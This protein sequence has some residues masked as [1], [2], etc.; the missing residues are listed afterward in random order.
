MSFNPWLDRL[1]GRWGDLA[2]SDASSIAH[3]PPYPT[4]D[5]PVTPDRHPSSWLDVTVRALGVLM[6]GALVA[7][8]CSFVRLLPPEGARTPQE[9]L[10]LLLVL[11]GIGLLGLLCAAVPAVYG[12]ANAWLAYGCAVTLGASSGLVVSLGRQL[13]VHETSV[14]PG[15]VSAAACV[16]LAVAALARWKT[17]AL[18]P[19]TWRVAVHAVVGGVLLL[20]FVYVAEGVGEFPPLWLLASSAAVASLGVSAWSVTRDVPRITAEV[21]DAGGAVWMA[22]FALLLSPAGGWAALASRL[23]RRPRPPLAAGPA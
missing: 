20:L 12:R 22:V 15:V 7:A 14:L 5:V 10:R 2:P 4:H 21:E 9:V 6:A 1:E 19:R 16:V 11:G 8:V 23:A 17:L 18:A 13:E 3:L